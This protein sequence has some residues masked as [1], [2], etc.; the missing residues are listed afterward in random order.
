MA[1]CSSVDK[2]DRAALRRREWERRNQETLQE[3][4]ALTGSEHLFKEPYKT[5]RGDELSS[6]IQSTLGSYDEMK[7]ILSNRSTQSRFVGIPAMS[8]PQTPSEKTEQSFFPDQR[9]AVMQP[10]Q[11]SSGTGRSSGPSSAST[12]SA[13]A[14]GSSAATGYGGPSFNQPSGSGSKKPGAERSRGSGSGG[15]GGGGGGHSSSSKSRH[16][17]SHGYSHGDHRRGEHGGGVDA[18]SKQQSISPAPTASSSHSGRHSYSRSS[19]TGGEHHGGTRASATTSS[20]AVEQ[21]H[22]RD[23]HRSKSPRE[24]PEFSSNSPGPS[25]SSSASAAAAASSSQMSSQAFPSSLPV[26]SK[27]SSLQQKPTAYVRP[28]DGQDQQLSSD[29]SELPSSSGP[30]AVTG[31]V[32]YSSGPSAYGGAV[33]DPKG[34]AAAAK[35]KLTKITIPPQPLE[36]GNNNDGNCVEEILREMAYPWPSPLTAIQTPVT[37]KPSKFPFPGKDSQH[38]NTSFPGTKRGDASS[39]SAT[40]TLA[41]NSMLEDDLKLSSDES[42]VELFADKSVLNKAI[43]PVSVPVAESGDAPRSSAES[44]S[45]SESESSS[46]SDSE[47]ETSSSDSEAQNQSVNAASPQPEPP[48]TNKWKLDNWL[49][50]VNLNTNKSATPQADTGNAK[51]QGHEYPRGGDGGAGGSGV[52]GGGGGSGGAQ[53][54]ERPNVAA[55]QADAKEKLRSPARERGKGRS[56]QRHADSKGGGGR[57]KSPAQPDV[58]SQRRS[59]GRKQPKKL[60][61]PAPSPEEPDYGYEPPKA[62]PTVVES[63]GGGGGSGVAAV[64]RSVGRKQPKRT[65]KPLSPEDPD[66]TKPEYA[67]GVHK[68]PAQPEVSVQQQQQQPQRRS[69]GRKQPR[70]IEKPASPDVENCP[71]SEFT[72]AQESSQKHKA[73][74]GALSGTNHEQ[75]KSKPKGGTGR[76]PAVKKET[77]PAPQCTAEAKKQRVP[78]KSMRKGREKVYSDTSSSSSS[79]SSDSESEPDESPAGKAD[80]PA[81]SGAAKSSGSDAPCDSPQHSDEG[82][83]GSAPPAPPAPQPPL[84]SRKEQIL[85]P[86]HVAGG[87][88]LSPIHDYD[89][90]RSLVVKIDLSLLARVPGRGETRGGGRQGQQQQQPPSVSERAGSHRQQSTSR[91]RSPPPPTTALGEKSKRKRQGDS[92]DIHSER[93]RG[94]VEKDATPH[95]AHKAAATK[96]DRKKIKVKTETPSH[97]SYKPPVNKE[98][99]KHTVDNKKKV[100]PPASPLSK[101]TAAPERK[102]RNSESSTSSRV[103]TVSEAGKSSKKGNPAGGA[104]ASQSSGKHRKL[105]GKTAGSA[106][107][108]NRE[109]SVADDRQV[110]EALFTK[111]GLCAVSPTLLRPR[112]VFDDKPQS[113]DFHMQEAKKLKHMA[114]GMSDKLG[115]AINYTDAGLSF[116]ECGNA[117]EQNPLEAKSPYTMYSETTDLVKYAMKLKS[118]S[119]PDSTPADKKLGVFSLRCLALLYLRMFKLKKDSAMKYSKSL[120]EHFKNASKM[121]QTPPWTGRGNGTPSPM[122]P[123]P[124]PAGSVGSQGSANTAAPSSSPVATVTIPQRIHQMA[125]SHVNITNH[126]LYGYDHWEQAELLAKENHEFFRDLDQLMGALT[127]NSS[128]TELVRYTRQGLHWLRFE[129]QLL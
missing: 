13:T 90:V 123:T 10:Y 16:S 59:I 33:P 55:S 84:L 88:L 120:L 43:I 42:D 100:A 126:F 114:D 37:A 94:K 98:S 76:K 116:I 80:S 75:P 119:A 107:M 44:G 101:S 106:K 64:R 52:G 34:S 67:F 128:M 56:G 129:G 65:E 2:K 125:A 92:E 15:A 79:P 73:G 7:D 81:P 27:Q 4:E 18:R 6:R 68:S 113:V 85:S 51:V 121:S 1:S 71:K 111:P 83:P 11:G 32:V 99:G 31:D 28:M 21:H 49:P 93:K 30:A 118:H 82:A 124:S 20:A 50:K 26:S 35:A 122:S 46:E 70:R 74:T 14:S 48:P 12:S 54:K 97:S 108:A 86:L 104:A 96:D 87:E 8:V 58:L 77:Q 91:E 89:E 17:S 23:R 69:V 3:E 39:K 109:E 72:L 40:N 61:K 47:S 25:S 19:A 62:S 117:M 102:R 53:D 112:L 110:S 115:K 22:G 95:S 38:V 5:N 78:G 105:D 41:D 9:T 45:S 36:A 127:L 60:E 63:S 29:C 103:S 57:Q 66:W 24:P